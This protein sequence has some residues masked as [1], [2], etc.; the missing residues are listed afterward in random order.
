[1][2]HPTG[3][4]E[5]LD[6]DR[7]V[8]ILDG[9]TDSVHGE[10]CK[11]YG[12]EPDEDAE[13]RSVEISDNPS[14][15]LESCDCGLKDAFEAWAIAKRLRAQAGAQTGAPAR[16]PQRID[17]TVLGPKGNCFSACIAMLLGLPIS[18]VPNFCEAPGFDEDP[19]VAFMKMAH[20]WLSARG[21]G[22]ITMDA[23]GMVF[24]RHYSKGYV[25]AAGMTE[26]GMLHSV[27][28]KDGELWHDPHP[29][30]AGILEVQEVDLLFPLFP[31]TAQGAGVAEGK[32]EQ[33]A[34][35]MDNSHRQQG[36]TPEILKPC[37]FCG[38]NKAYV[39]SGTPCS[40]HSELTTW[41][42]E[43]GGYGCEFRMS[44][45]P[46]E[47]LA[48]KYWNSRPQG[49]GGMPQ[50]LVWTK[51]KPTADGYYWKRHPK[52]SSTTEACQLAGGTVYLLR[53]WGRSYWPMEEMPNDHEWAGPIPEPV[54]A[55]KEGSGHPTDHKFVPDA[56]NVSDCGICG[57][58]EPNAEG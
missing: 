5:A 27:I 39:E 24:K 15:F 36:E 17:Q 16:E 11:A 44:E 26:R 29:S 14:A 8:K 43:C 19:G 38:E 34:A 10:D 40:D 3:A 56:D 30:H 25:M 45:Q 49:A 21:W 41:R 4:R 46:T 1:M 2:T 57:W 31:F 52:V 23:P 35:I 6:L 12:A 48:R 54:E 18:E 47:E 51:E 7:L 50:A 28:Y 53:A 33:I 9:I 58:E 22:H 42:V 20:A 55:I 13:S 32:L 37:P